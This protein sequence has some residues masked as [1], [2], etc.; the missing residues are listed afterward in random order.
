MVDGVRADP[1]AAIRAAAFAELDRLRFAHGPKLPWSV[2]DRGFRFR[3]EKIHFAG[4]AVG[5]FKPRQMSAALSIKTVAPRAGRRFWYRDQMGEPD[6]RTGL[7]AYDLA[8]GGRGDSTNRAL[9]EAYSRS[10]ALIYFVGVSPA[11]YEPLSPVWVEELDFD[12]GRVLLAAA[13]AF[14]PTMSSIQAAQAAGSSAELRERSYTLVAT[15]RRNH[16]AWFSSRTK[17]AYGHRCAFSGL[18]LSRLLVG[19]HILPD[20]EDGPAT[21]TNGICMSTLHHTAFDADLI[22]VDTNCRIHVARSVRDG[23][24]GPLLESLKGLDG[25]G[26]R[27]PARSED[28]P[29]REFLDWRFQRFLETAD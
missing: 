27:L 14:H 10:A 23:R 9:E 22:G 15:K 12:A 11:V 17:S 13:D 28:H 2:I 25:A 16:Q 24:D 29:D 20:A 26:L 7:L 21:V 6:Y 1:D 3:G 8:R 19:A 5:I 4:R 18:T